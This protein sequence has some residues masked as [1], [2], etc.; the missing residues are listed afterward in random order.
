MQESF[1]ISNA[2]GRRGVSMRMYLEC[3]ENDKGT[4]IEIA[5]AIINKAFEGVNDF[6]LA[7]IRKSELAEIAEHIQ[8]FLKYSEVQK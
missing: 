4:P 8:V 3:D 5:N 7:K 1:Y 2:T 6:E